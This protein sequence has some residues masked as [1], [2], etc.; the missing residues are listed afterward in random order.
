MRDN[1]INEKIDE[2]I[3]NKEMEKFINVSIK[4]IKIRTKHGHHLRNS[5]KGIPKMYGLPETYKI[6][7]PV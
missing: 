7:I 4:L 5:T 6:N 1:K 2:Q 3:I